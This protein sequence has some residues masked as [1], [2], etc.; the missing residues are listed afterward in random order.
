M[1]HE[2]QGK[3][4][5]GWH[6]GPGPTGDRHQPQSPVMRKALGHSSSKEREGRVPPNSELPAFPRAPNQEAGNKRRGRDGEEAYNW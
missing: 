3:A 5:A 4:D 2:Q 6:V 1:E